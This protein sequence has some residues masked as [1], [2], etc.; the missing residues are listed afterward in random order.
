MKNVQEICAAFG[1]ATVLAKE[2]G[3]NEPAVSRWALRNSIPSKWLVAVADAAADHNID[4]SIVGMA[5]IMHEDK[6]KRDKFVNG[7]RRGRKPGPKPRAS[8]E[9]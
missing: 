9:A 7:R 5:K 6:L 2:I 3:F 8:L 1:G 4:I